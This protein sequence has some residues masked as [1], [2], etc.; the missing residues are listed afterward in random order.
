MSLMKQV[1]HICQENDITFDQFML[2]YYIDDKHTLVKIVDKITN[3]YEVHQNL[4]RRGLVRFITSDT[5]NYLKIDNILLTPKGQEIVDSFVDGEYIENTPDSDFIDDY[6]NIF[7]PAKSSG[8]RPIKG[9]K[10]SCNKK[11]ERFFKEHPNI[12]KEEISQA[13]TNY[14]IR[15]S[16]DNYAFVTCADYFIYKKDKSGVEVSLLEAEVELVKEGHIETSG[17]E[18]TVKL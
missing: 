16:K 5:D 7:A 13:A 1:W 17:D 6:R 10:A 2:M 3:F 4:H 9:S 15:K 18:F 11:M 12:T 14:M 8:G